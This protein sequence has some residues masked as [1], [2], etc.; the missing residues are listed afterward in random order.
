M[1]KVACEQEVESATVAQIAARAGVSRST[2]YQLFENRE[3]CFLAT[4]EEAVARAA[5][6]AVVAYE[7]EGRW[8]DRVRA[9]LGSLLVFFDEQ[10]QLARVCVVH[11]LAAGPQTLARRAEVLENLIQVIDQGRRRSRD[12][13]QP[14][15]TAESAVG[16]VLAVIHGRLLESDPDPLTL[17]LRPLMFM[18]TLP[19]LGLAAAR[20]ELVQPPAKRAGARDRP[21]STPPRAP[22]DLDMRLTYRTLRVLAAIAAAPGVNNREVAAAVE[23]RD[24]GQISKLLARLQRHGLARNTGPGQPNGGPNAWTLTAR[25]VKVGRDAGRA[26]S[27][28]GRDGRPE[29]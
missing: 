25:G 28:P 18:I 29:R 2:F 24:Q 17:L 9:G 7:A 10:P 22:R 5:E 16:G 21:Q 14:P 19:Y 3:A 4:F 11:A 1:A 13:A 15:L 12:G 6:T 8:V 23:V 27:H 26:T 20:R